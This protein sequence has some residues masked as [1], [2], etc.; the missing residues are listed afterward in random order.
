MPAKFFLSI[1]IKVNLSLS[2]FA[3][4]VPGIAFEVLGLGYAVQGGHLRAHLLAMLLNPGHIDES[5]PNAGVPRVLLHIRLK[6][7][8]V[9]NL[10]ND[11]LNL[12]RISLKPRGVVNRSD[13]IL[14]L[15][16]LNGGQVCS[17]VSRVSLS[18]LEES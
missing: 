7:R 3:L 18:G 9:V 1:L 15:V 5:C 4:R 10:R 11:M 2:L 14:S 17:S 6:P 13:D 12:V 16:H 8:G